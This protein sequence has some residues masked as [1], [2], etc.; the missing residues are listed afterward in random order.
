MGGSCR[1]LCV[2]DDFP[3]PILGINFP[4]YKLLG[5]RLKRCS[6]CLYLTVTAFDICFCCGQILRTRK[7]PNN[8]RKFPEKV[9]CLNKYGFPVEVPYRPDRFN[10]LKRRLQFNY[11]RILEQNK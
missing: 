1:N 6:H 7:S 10:E 3:C 2:Y 4:A 8:S 5:Y 11:L 9:M